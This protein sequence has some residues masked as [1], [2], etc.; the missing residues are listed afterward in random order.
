MVWACMSYKMAWDPVWLHTRITS[1][2]YVDLLDMN[3][4]KAA[5][6]IVP[7]EWVFQ[8]DNAP[9]HRSRNT[10][11]WLVAKKIEVMDWSALSSDFKPI[12]ILSGSWYAIFTRIRRSKTHRKISGRRYKLLLRVSRNK[13]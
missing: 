2:V 1:A 4:K 6:V 9:A 5:A 8:Q 3:L 10:M 12:E 11:D 7:N 13:T